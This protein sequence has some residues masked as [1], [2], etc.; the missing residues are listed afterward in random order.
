M[1]LD[2]MDSSLAGFPL[3]SVSFGGAPA[4][5]MLTKQAGRVFPS[6]TLHV[7]N[8]LALYFLPDASM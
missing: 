3:E 4:P 1:A 6:A 8:F 5:D 7:P 2:L